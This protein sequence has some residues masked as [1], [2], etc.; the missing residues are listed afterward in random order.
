M[1]TSIT[2]LANA[3]MEIV[4]VNPWMPALQ[5]RY[6]VRRMVDYGAVCLQ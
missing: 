1:S 6:V 5:R 3:Y 2:L 4:C